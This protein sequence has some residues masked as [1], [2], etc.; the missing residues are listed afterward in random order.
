MPPE[1]EPPLSHAPLASRGRRTA[2]RSLAGV[3]AAVLALVGR[4]P[5]NDPDGPAAL[6]VDAAHKKKRRKRGRTGPTG[7]TGQP[8]PTGPVGTTG[9]LRPY[10]G[11]VAIPPGENSTVQVNCEI[12]QVT[13]GGAIIGNISGCYLVSSSAL[14]TIGWSATGKCDPGNEATMI[15]RAI[16]LG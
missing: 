2:V 15:V 12:G 8:G 16:C 10:E 14:G 7:P 13:G 1:Q 3:G 11:S 4:A 5:S 9:I 6:Q